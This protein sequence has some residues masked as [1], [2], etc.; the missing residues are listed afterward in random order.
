MIA[1]IKGIIVEK[2]D[3]KLILS[4]NSGLGYEV[5]VTPKLL[6][7]PLSEEVTISTYCHVKEDAWVLFG[8]ESD[9][10][11]KMFIKLLSVD[12][13]GPKTAFTIISTKTLSELTLAIVAKDVKIFEDVSG[14]GKKTAARIILELSSFLR[15]EV[16]IN[17]LLH[18]ERKLDATA[19]E[20]LTTLGF[21]K[22][23][24][25]TAL[26]ELSENLTFDES[27]KQALKKLSST[28][29]E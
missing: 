12:G 2:T 9:S 25:M 23:S 5:F 13:V 14:V 11:K 29:Y 8:F 27:I 19:I 16:D 26:M 4:T 6:D 28:T 17:T 22:K 7:F 15:D 20:T 21:S 3:K 18:G 24:V 1:Q 10:Q